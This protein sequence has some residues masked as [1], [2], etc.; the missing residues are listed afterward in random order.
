[1]TTAV[2]KCRGLTRPV[3]FLARSTWKT[4][5]ELSDY[6]VLNRQRWFQ[7]ASSG[8]D[9][10][11]FTTAAALYKRPGVPAPAKEKPSQPPTAVLAQKVRPSTANF[12]ETLA[13]KASPTI[14]YEAAPQRGFVFS[15]YTAAL[16]CMSV[17]GVNHWINVYNIPPGLPW[18]VPYGF[19]VVSFCM[20]IPA[21]VFALRPAAVVRSVKVLPT[22]AT[23]GSSVAN[24]AH[25]AA[26][27]IQLEI[28][29]RSHIPLPGLPFKRIVVEPHQVVMK[30][31][32]YN[33]KLSEHEMK[34]AEKEKEE[35][36]KAERQYD[37]DH[38]MTAPF[39]HAKWAI[40]TIFHGLRRGLTGEGFAPIWV[41]GIRYKI[42]ISDAYVM[43]NGR[44]L[45]R[46]VR[47]EES[48]SLVRRSVEPNS[49]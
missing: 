2:P 3:M 12:L 15:S 6:A 32:M 27:P 19:G 43:D 46:I 13:Q 33:P 11:L 49:R 36:R 17:G 10:R 38:L 8:L 7:L 1:M 28:M 40:S 23:Q 9:G 44:A 47:I 39:R 35:R 4:S 48:E 29:A 21:T 24:K 37:M 34:Q 20:A 30:A 26:Q 22:R 25:S 5:C 16:F 31:R 41:K 42:P 14:L 45:D 18:W